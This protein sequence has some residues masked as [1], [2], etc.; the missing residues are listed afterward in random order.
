[1]RNGGDT[2]ELDITDLVTTQKEISD[3]QDEY[4]DQM[5]DKLNDLESKLSQM[6]QIFKRL[7][8]SKLRLRSTEK[9]HLKKN[10]N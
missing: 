9:S 2:E 8:I 6:D 1:M 7:M 3:K 4:M 10:Y 5:F